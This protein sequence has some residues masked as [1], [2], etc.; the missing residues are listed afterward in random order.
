MPLSA[1]YITA[2][3]SRIHRYLTVIPT[4]NVAVFAKGAATSSIS[5]RPI[6]SAVDL[7]EITLKVNYVVNAYLSCVELP[8][9]FLS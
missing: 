2:L 3:V 9:L 4:H 1:V 5:K 8:S 7:V 6:S